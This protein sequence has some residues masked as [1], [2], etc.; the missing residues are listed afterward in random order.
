MK[1]TRNL[2]RVSEEEGLHERARCTTSQRLCFLWC[3]LRHCRRVKRGGNWLTQGSSLLLGEFCPSNGVQVTTG[4]QGTLNDVCKYRP[5]LCHCSEALTSGEVLLSEE[6]EVSGA[7]VAQADL[8]GAEMTASEKFSG[9]LIRLNL[10]YAFCNRH[11]EGR[12]QPQ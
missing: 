9:P 11:E 3:K 2:L 1:R 8:G 5:C 10:P 4:G 12:S 6:Q 7:W